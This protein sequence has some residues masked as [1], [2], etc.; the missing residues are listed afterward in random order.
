MQPVKILPRRKL[1]EIERKTRSLIDG[2]KAPE[3]AFQMNSDIREDCAAFSDRGFHDGPSLSISELGSLQDIHA[4]SR[5]INLNSQD[6]RAGEEFFMRGRSAAPVR[7]SGGQS[8]HAR[9]DTGSA[10]KHEPKSRE[11]GSHGG[12]F[13]QSVFRHFC[14]DVA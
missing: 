10:A 14:I 7:T 11:E 9:A 6:L 2:A 8:A 12:Q 13:F 5:D 3:P 1:I 4:R